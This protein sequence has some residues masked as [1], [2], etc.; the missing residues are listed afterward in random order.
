MSWRAGWVNLSPRFGE[1][2]PLCRNCPAI[3]TRLIPGA[4]VRGLQCRLQP[5]CSRTQRRIQDDQGHVHQTSDGQRRI[6]RG[7]AGGRWMPTRSRRFGA[8]FQSCDVA[9]TPTE[10]KWRWSKPATSACPSHLAAARTAQQ[11]PNVDVPVSKIGLRP[12]FS[13]GVL[14]NSADRELVIEAHDWFRRRLLDI[15]ECR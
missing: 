4:A 5:T 1:R 11:D 14:A 6:L 3:Q 7:S 9:G 10:R 13:L 12:A 8:Q 15:P 2:S